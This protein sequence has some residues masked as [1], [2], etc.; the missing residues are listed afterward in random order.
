M[1]FLSTYKIPLSRG[2][3]DKS[4]Y[5]EDTSQNSPNY[6][7]VQDFPSLVGGGRYVIKLKGNG[8]NMRINTSID[9]EM[10]DAE[11]QRIFCEVSDFADRFGY[12]Y[13]SFDIYD[14]TAQG[15]AT[16]CLVGEAL[17]DLNGNPIPQQFANQYNVRWIKSFNIAPYERNNA[18]LLFDKPPQVSVAQIVTPT[19]IMTQATTSL[20]PYAYQTSSA[21]QLSIITSNFQG[22][23]RDFA[24]SVDI[25]DNRLRDIT[26]NPRNAPKTVNSVPT[27]LRSLDDD[28]DNGRLINYTTR[29][30][31]IVKST[32]SFFRKEHLGG[33]FDFYGTGSSPLNLYPPLPAGITVSGSVNT[34]LDSYESIVVEV[35][36]DTQAVISKPLTITTLDGNTIGN[37]PSNYTYKAANS[38]TGSVVYIPSDKSYVTSSN[39]NQSYVEFTFSDL[40][41]IS[42]QV[43]RIKTAARL[44]SVTGDYKLLSDQI[45]NPVEYLTDAQ[46]PNAVNYARYESDYLLIGHFFTQSLITTYWSAY[47]EDPAGFDIIT[48]SLNNNILIDSVE[49]KPSYSQSAILTST[50]NQNYNSNQIYTMGFYL[51]LEPYT[52]L[53]VYANS[54]PLNTYI[55]SPSTYPRA[56]TRTLNSDKTRYS[57]DYN[58]F[59][60]YLG[61]IVNDRPQRKYYGKVLFDFETDGSGFGRPLFRA[62]VVDQMSGVVGGAYVSEIS[63]KPYT[64]NGFTPNL[65]Q[66]AVPLPQELVNAAT[67]SQSIDFKIDYYDYTGKQSEYVTY[68]DDLKLNLK[69]EIVSNTC[70]TDRLKFSY[71]SNF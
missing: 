68:L 15:T 36:N 45:V 9:I 29:F 41:P 57:S 14:I 50:Y 58:R 42:G 56:F 20:V 10:I 1:S 52:E 12:F 5:V 21:N 37:A 40:N 70:Q 67:L 60:K 49:M 33:Y 8:A 4:Y 13:I 26:V 19:R 3:F 63:I 59:G 69:S 25:L 35:V 27:A 18:E 43:Y 53:E 11:G 62:R 30:N 6:F 54:I 47:K 7:D 32:S 51:T 28:I 31:T 23:D 2:Y 39:V 61:K 55:I 22:Y 34:Q 71:N 64:I 66:Y 46:Y 24:S 17:I 44:G 48:G 16:A 65:V 38:F